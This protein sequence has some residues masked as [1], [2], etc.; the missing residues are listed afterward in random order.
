MQARSRRR[1]FALTDLVAVCTLGAVVG[2][3]LMPGV[4]APGWGTTMIAAQRGHFARMPANS[5]RT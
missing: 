3:I 5:S 1:G 4:G 2:T